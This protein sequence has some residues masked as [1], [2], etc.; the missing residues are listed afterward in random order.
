MNIE[1]DLKQLLLFM[2]LEILTRINC[3]PTTPTNDDVEGAAI[4]D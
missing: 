2:M 4:I 3:I 1:L